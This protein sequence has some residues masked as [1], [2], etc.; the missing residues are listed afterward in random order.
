MK[1]AVLKNWLDLELCDIPVPVCGEN[2]ALIKVIRAGV[3]G[4][5]IT[6]YKG[7]H[8]TATVPTVLSHEILGTIESLPSDYTGKFH[9]GQRVL[10]N[11]IISCGTCSAC[12]RGLPWVCENLKLMGIHVDG[13]FAE[14]TKVAVDKL[15]AVGDDFPDEVAILGEPFAVGQ[16]VMKNSK[17]QPGDK[18][19]ISGGATVGLYI[20]IFAKAAGASDVIISEI[21]EP[22]RQFVESMGIRTIN[23]S[24]TDAMD[25]MREV[26]GGGGFDIVYDTSGAPACALQMPDLCRCGGKL[27]SLNLSGDA[28]QFVLGKVSFKEITLVGNRLYSQ[29]DFEQGVRFVEENWRTLHLDRMVTDRLG[30]SEIDRAFEMMLNGENICKIIIDPAR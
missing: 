22:R 2:E 27:L 19:F 11:P 30:L 23:P 29:E 6:V 13:G 15:V 10:M 9:V 1:A 7:K 26:T 18:I 4:S 16:H 17:V 28:Y 5:D 21:N 25:L 20:A 14:Y 8:M 3:C 12:R 24:Q